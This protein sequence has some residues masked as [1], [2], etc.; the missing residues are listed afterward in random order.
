MRVSRVTTLYGTTTYN[1][2]KTY[3]TQGTFLCN[4]VYHVVIHAWLV[5]PIVNVYVL[6]T[7]FIEALYA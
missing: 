5:F 6:R 7:L 4:T 3:Y 1:A 2:R